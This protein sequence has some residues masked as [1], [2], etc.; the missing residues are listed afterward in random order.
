MLRLQSVPYEAISQWLYDFQK[1]SKC[2][3]LPPEEANFVGI[4]HNHELIG[5]F[6]LLGFNKSE[7]EI[8]QGYLVSRFRHLGI[9]K[10]CMEMLER[11]CK[12]MGYKTVLLGTHNRFKSYLKFA[13]GLGY[14]PKHLVFSK[15]I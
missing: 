11:E 3:E 5:Y 12:K 1:R 9:Y 7:V 15:E 6:V 14:S 10:D 2:F 4:F 8:H 13:K